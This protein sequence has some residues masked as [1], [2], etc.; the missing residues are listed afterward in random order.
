M[1]LPLL[2]LSGL[3]VLSYWK[4]ASN[5]FV[6][7]VCFGLV[8]SGLFVAAV[9]LFD[10]L[11]TVSAA[12]FWGDSKVQPVA[13]SHV[14]SLQITDACTVF[15]LEKKQTCSILQD[16]KFFWV[17]HHSLVILT[18]MLPNKEGGGEE[19][20]VTTYCFLFGCGF[21]MWLYGRCETDKQVLLLKI[22]FRNHLWMP[23]WA[24]KLQLI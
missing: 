16:A 21:I 7:V 11:H 14:Q 2:P 22:W 13:V 5:A 1:S 20:Q 10:C 6:R 4:P 9:W 18:V 12:F 15:V 23:V 17:T 3:L 19:I 24:I 8:A